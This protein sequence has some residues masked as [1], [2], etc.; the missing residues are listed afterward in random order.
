M[1]KLAYED[2]E[3]DTIML[4]DQNLVVLEVSLSTHK[5]ILHLRR[6]L[7]FIPVAYFVEHRMF[8][9]ELHCAFN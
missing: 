8:A 1:R 9:Q 2:G 6:I 5:R 7:L 4:G 3:I